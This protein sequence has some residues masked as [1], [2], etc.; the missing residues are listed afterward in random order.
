M[1]QI[2]AVLRW[3][4]SAENDLSTA[5]DLMKAGHCDWALFLGQLTLEKLLKGLVTQKLDDA[6]P[7]THDLLKLAN[8]AK[9]ELTEERQS[10]LQEITTY[11]I[12]ARYGYIKDRLYQKATK[13]YSQ[14]WFGKIEE[15]Y[16]WLN[17]K[18]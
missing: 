18:F 4:K 10:E 7:F 2:E 9:I 12:N 3:R 15:Y 17:N 11:H 5:K 1:T 13:E 16:L 14:H 6:P 8:T